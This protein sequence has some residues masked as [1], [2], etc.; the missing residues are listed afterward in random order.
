MI[1]AQAVQK[2]LQKIHPK[3]TVEIQPADGAANQLPDQLL[4]ANDGKGL[5]TRAVEQN[6]LWEK[7]DVAVHCLKDLPTVD[8]PGLVLAAIPARADARDAL[9]ARDADTI[10]DLPSG[11][12]VGTS[13]PRRAAHLLHMRPDLEIQPL[14]GNI[15]TRLSSVLEDDQFD[16]TLLAMAGMLRGGFEKH[17]TKPLPLEDFLPS[18]GQGALAIQCRADDHVT[19]RR[20]LPLNN[21]TAATLC[22]AERQAAQEL[23]GGCQA[24]VGIYA[25]PTEEGQ[26][27]LRARALSLDGQ[28]CVEVDESGPIK[29]ARHLVETVVEKMNAQGAQPIIDAAREATPA[30]PITEAGTLDA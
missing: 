9:I 21:V 12:V 19:M 17:A 23:G 6:L 15:D 1:Q 11:A 28:Q 4:H 10:S 22:N 20:C 3:V 8:T 30:E 2:V 14:R 26:M 16:A 29:S 13:S 18:P 7:A 24:P 5:F 27:R 25:E